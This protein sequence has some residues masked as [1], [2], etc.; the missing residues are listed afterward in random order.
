MPHNSASTRRRLLDAAI[1]EFSDHGL[2]GARVQVIADNAQANKQAI[3]A[4]Y[5]SK[6]G[7]FVAAFEDRIA[8]WR[9]AIRFDQDDL[10]ESAGRMFDE[11][12]RTPATWRLMFWASIEQGSSRPPLPAL[13]Q[14]YEDYAERIRVAQAEGHVTTRYSPPMILGLIRSLVLT[15]QV[16]AVELGGRMPESQAERRATIVEAITTLLDDE[17]HGR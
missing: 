1:V 11:Y 9:E 5:G 2:S 16:Q 4:Y 3:Y 10:P 12:A 6:E 8:R 7:L 13:S 15:W 17:T 14:M